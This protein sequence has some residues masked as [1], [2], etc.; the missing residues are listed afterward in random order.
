[1]VYLMHK[2]SCKEEK[3]MKKIMAITAAAVM[4]LTSI[5]ANAAE[6]DRTGKLYK[7]IMDDS[8]IHIIYNDTA[9]E[10]P[11]VKPVNA[12]GRVMIPFRAALE[13][14]GAQVDYDGAKREVT[15]EKGNKEIKFTL[16]G[17][18][19]T[20][21]TDGDM[22]SE[23]KM[24][25][26]MMIVD[27]STLVP[28]RFMSNAFG[29]QIGWDGDTQSVVIL[30][31]DTYFADFAD[32]APNMSKLLEIDD[33][34]YN[35]EYTE[36]DFDVTMS[37]GKKKTNF[38]FDGN[39]DAVDKDGAISADMTFDMSISGGGLPITVKDSYV[40]LIMKDGSVYLK[41]D[42]VEQLA[43]VI[44]TLDMVTAARIINKN[45]WYKLDL[46]KVLDNIEMPEELK[47]ILIAGDASDLTIEEALIA[48]IPADGDVTLADMIMLATQ[49]DT[50][51][52]MDKYIAV[53]EKTNGGYKVS[54]NITS[55]DFADMMK[56]MLAGFMP[57][58][59]LAGINNMLVFEI[60]AN[61]DAD[62]KVSNSDVKLNIEMKMEDLFNM[63]MTMNMTDK[64]E[65]SD[66]VKTVEIPAEAM[67]VTDIIFGEDFSN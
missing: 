60:S 51:Q 11:D 8:Q 54:M 44:G 46:N 43:A 23:I 36:F 42:V 22:V 15:A 59:E 58:E 21:I 52:M 19:I 10:C 48:A 14:M 7:T 6:A 28:I 65:N 53:E 50:Y 26:P 2:Q 67:D 27:G 4:M 9:I 63:T 31:R 32:I 61:T 38:A 3:I 17:D 20:V 39:I 62:A 55:D 66:T 47:N 5:G 30:D 35:K 16:M 24:D 1:M 37:D 33:I 64:A 41:T 56:S 57:E 29:M 12:D 18:T 25:T 13:G 40:N 49:L 34:E 45:T